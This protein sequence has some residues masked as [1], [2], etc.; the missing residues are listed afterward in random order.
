VSGGG[1]VLLLGSVAG[2]E[3]ACVVS[4]GKKKER[5]FVL[6]ILEVRKRA[7]DGLCLVVE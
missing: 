6:L 1:L 7:C 5:K 3:N 2:T 4:K